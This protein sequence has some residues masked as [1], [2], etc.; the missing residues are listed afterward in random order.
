MQPLNI[1]EKLLTFDVSRES[2]WNET[3]DVYPPNQ[4]ERFVGAIAPEII[5]AKMSVVVNELFHGSD[6][7]YSTTV[8]GPSARTGRML[9]VMVRVSTLQEMLELLA[10]NPLLSAWG[11]IDELAAISGESRGGVLH[12]LIDGI[13]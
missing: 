12:D 5:T 13:R 1:F 4:F 8:I 3:R 2:A 6:E 7:P 11:L 9:S 10:K